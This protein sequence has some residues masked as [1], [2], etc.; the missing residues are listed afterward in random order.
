M[1]AQALFALNAEY[2]F[3]DKGCLEATKKFARQPNQFSRRLE[4]VLAL[5][6]AN[7]AELESAVQQ[8]Q[9]LWQEV[10]DLTNLPN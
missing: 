5:R 3:G 10:A 7:P 2:Y 9:I 1:L 4:E 8:M 6:M